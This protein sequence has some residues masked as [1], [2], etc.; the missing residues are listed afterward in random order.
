MR[1][2]LLCAI[3]ILMP[4]FGRSQENSPLS[5]EEKRQILGQLFELRSCRD[6]TRAYEQYVARDREQDAREK[7]NLERS[8]ELER[9]ATALAQKERDIERDRAETYEKLYRSLTKGPG[10][11]C[12]LKRVFTLGIHRCR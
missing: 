3:L 6:E 8:L 10:I 12:I 4:R 1:I 7:A 5:P 2:L 9:Q 11:G